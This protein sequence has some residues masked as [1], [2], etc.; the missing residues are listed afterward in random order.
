[1]SFSNEDYR[2]SDMRVL[3]THLLYVYYILIVFN[4]IYIFFCKSYDEMT[5]KFA[6]LNKRSID[7]L[8]HKT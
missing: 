5:D 1:M 3:K 2:D 7:D 8:I 6:A 4:T